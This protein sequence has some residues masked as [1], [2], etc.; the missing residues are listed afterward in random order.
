MVPLAI[1]VDDYGLHAGVNEAATAL[2]RAGRVSA[3]GAMVGAPAWA[4]GVPALR[5]LSPRAVDVGLHLDLTDHPLHPGLRRP[6]AQWLL[7]A[8]WSPPVR[9]GVRREIRAQLAAFGDAMGRPPAY[10]DGHEHVHQLPGVRAEVLAALASFSDEARPWLRST[11]PA[12][13]APWGGGRPWLLA[14]LG[15]RTLARQARRAGCRQN[16]HLLGVYDY[17][18][19]AARYLALAARWLAAAGPGD[20]WMC[21]PAAR[22]P[23]DDRLGPVRVAEYA[24]LASRAFGEL[25]EQAGVRVAPLSGLGATGAGRLS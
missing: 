5:A 25:L 10:V 20:L 16:A 2:A 3:I 22:V 19:D 17:R 14:A 13:S 12:P 7:G 21:H 23:P 11:Q 8:A 18:A 1:C 15:G 6:L 4:E 24:A 9:E